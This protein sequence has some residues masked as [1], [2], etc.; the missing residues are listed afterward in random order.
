MSSKTTTKTTGF[1]G[2]DADFKCQNFQYEVGKTYQHK[3]D[4]KLCPT[5]NEAN[6]GIG[7]FHFCEFPLAVWDYYPPIDSRFA[8]IETTDARHHDDKRPSP[9]ISQ[10][11][12]N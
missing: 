3:G 12:R 4:V 6:R 11:R 7:G 8:A 9:A 10:L 1:K 5:A 2:F